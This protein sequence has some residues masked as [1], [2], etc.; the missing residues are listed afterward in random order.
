MRVRFYPVGSA[1]PFLVSRNRTI[2]TQRK[3]TWVFTPRYAARVAHSR[4]AVLFKDDDRYILYCTG[5]PIVSTKSRR[6]LYQHAKREIRQQ[7]KMYGASLRVSRSVH[8]LNRLR[9]LP[10]KRIVAR[11][12]KC[13]VHRSKLR[14]VGFPFFVNTIKIFSD[15]EDDYFEMKDWLAE[16]GIHY[17]L[18][19]MAFRFSGR[20]RAD[21]SM[22]RI[23]FPDENAAFEYKMRWM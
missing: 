23:D 6:A 12:R 14:G 7:E 17:H 21:F 10:S 2:D 13:P 20:T 3:P 1:E 11:A 16:R 19:R 15:R 18:N 9:D 8:M 5:G 4:Q 22:F